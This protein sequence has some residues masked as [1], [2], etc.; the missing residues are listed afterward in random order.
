MR[1]S[2][3]P[4]F[5]GGCALQTGERRAFLAPGLFQSHSLFGESHVTPRRA[6]SHRQS[7]PTWA[8]PGNLCGDYSEVEANG[9]FLWLPGRAC[10]D[11]AGCTPS[12]SSHSSCAL[13][14]E[15]HT[16]FV[17][18]RHVCLSADHAIEDSG[19]EAVKGVYLQEGAWSCSCFSREE[20]CQEEEAPSGG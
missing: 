6:L 4:N 9:G 18:I 7:T 20:G 13:E 10:P 19:S 17:E 14:S 2:H 16:P 11:A 1:G 12:R 15:P 8:C 3:S 5:L